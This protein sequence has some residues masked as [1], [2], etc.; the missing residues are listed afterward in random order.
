[1]K[2]LTKLSA[3]SLMTTAF[4]LGCVTNTKHNEN[5][6]ESR[7]IEF[8]SSAE[9]FNTKT[10]FYVG[11][12]EVVA[13]DAQFTESNATASIQHLRKFTDKPITWLVITHPNPDKFNGANVFR[14]E[15]AKVIAST[16]TVNNIPAVHG[17]KK[18]YFVEMAK[19]FTNET[20]PSEPTIDESFDTQLSLRLSGGETIELVEYNKPG[21]STNQTVAILPNKQGLIVGDLIHYKAHAWLEGGIVDSK[22]TP[23]I[24]SWVSLLKQITE[25][26]DSDIKVYGGR[27]EAT[28]LLEAIEVQ[29]EYL[30]KADGIVSNYVKKLGTKK[31]ELTTEKATK[32]YENLT[33]EFQSTFPDYA[34]SYMVQYGIYGLVNSKLN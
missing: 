6:S 27:G 13:F 34:L 12:K 10:I 23:T 21:I 5:L 26:N 18:Y 2:N 3:L 1:M 19:M 29:I 11:K 15:G 7:V 25:E 31:S 4:T 16:A 8:E 14:S 30:Q 9:G 28:N 32:H 17:Y 20:Y 22:A 24:S 33:Q